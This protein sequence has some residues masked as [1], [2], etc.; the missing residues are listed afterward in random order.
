MH[1]A[2][3]AAHAF[4]PVPAPETYVAPKLSL[5][6]APSTAPPPVAP[7]VERDR[8]R[9]FGDAIDA[10]KQRT[11]E[12]IGP[13]D[14]AYVRRVNRFSRTMEVTGR[15]LIHF[16][17]EPVSF[18]LGVG[19]LWLHKQLQATEIG[20]TALHGAYDRI[21]G[22]EQF[23]SREFEWDIPIDE[24]SWR[25]G[26]NVK[27]HGNTNIA[28]KDPDI[29]FGPARLTEQTPHSRKNLIQLPFMLGFLAPNFTFLMNF[30][31]TGLNDAYWDNGLPSKFDVL[32]DR[33]PESVREAWRKSLRKYV[34][35]YFKNYVLFPVLAGPF[36][37]KVLLGNWMAETMRD[38]YSA[39]TIF[40]GHVGE[41][42]ASYPEG[43]KAT[44]RGEWYA[45]QCAASNDFQVSWPV[46]VLC[47]GLDL[48][49]EHHLFPTFAPQ[50]LREIAP[51]VEALCKEHGVPYRKASWG[52]T[53]RKAIAHIAAL[54]HEGGARAVVR[55]MA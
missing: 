23:H 54:S 6:E 1:A 50:R 26:H 53:L 13:E 42:V 41:D 43:T 4:A 3:S 16:S 20:H 44:T 9:E 29:H 30:H 52:K 17:F 19:A 39:A 55:A 27:H 22:A 25:L 21:E 5:V 2:S 7:P 24:E 48:Q 11:M 34:P 10:L 40:C 38:V 51:E 35:Y 14:L 36:F 37:W 31:F 12:R 47:G 33:S 18:L 8:H 49:I 15:L 28:G 46:S 32:K 45:M